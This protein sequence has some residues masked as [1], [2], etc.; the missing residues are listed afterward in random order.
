MKKSARGEFVEPCVLS[1]ALE[2]LAQGEPSPFPLP[3]ETYVAIVIL[4]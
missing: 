1:V 2:N 3:E 4:S